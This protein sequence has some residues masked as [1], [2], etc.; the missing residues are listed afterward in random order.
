MALSPAAV[1]ANPEAA[2]HSR[3]L[4]RRYLTDAFF[5]ADERVLAETVADP[6]L[7]ERAWLF[8]AAYTDRILDEVDVLFAN[9]DGSRVACHLTADVVQIGSWITSAIPPDTGRLTRL[10]CTAI[11]FIADGK[12]VNFY[13]TWR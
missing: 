7:Q 13:E 10:E 8:W 11:Y 3:E 6:V 1:V 12:I 4:V 5:G 9:A 2:E